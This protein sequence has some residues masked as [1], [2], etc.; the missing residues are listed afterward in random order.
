[1]D[2]SL[3]KFACI[4]V[5][6][7]AAAALGPAGCGGGS[8]DDGLWDDVVS[9]EY[10]ATGQMAAAQQG[11]MD[12]SEADATLARNLGQVLERHP[13]GDPRLRSVI[14]SIRDASQRLSE[15]QVDDAEAEALREQHATYW[16]HLRQRELPPDYQ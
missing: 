6:M 14:E 7:V 15:G 11:A 5:A 4:A 10:L 8:S 3:T 2:L 16:E 9:I 13:D 1:M 12:Q